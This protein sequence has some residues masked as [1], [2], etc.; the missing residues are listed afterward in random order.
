M[1]PST[2]L[3]IF[4]PV[5]VVVAEEASG[6]QSDGEIL[7]TWRLVVVVV[8]AGSRAGAGDGAFA[9]TT[10]R[11]P[12]RP[13]CCCCCGV[14]D[15]SLSSSPLLSRCV[16]HY[17]DTG[18]QRFILHHTLDDNDDVSCANRQLSRTAG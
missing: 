17:R 7:R 3:P 16:M 11:R 5:L 2:D 13:R 10:I 9:G 15:R 18:P 6:H 4:L 12:R 1:S 8:A 14:T